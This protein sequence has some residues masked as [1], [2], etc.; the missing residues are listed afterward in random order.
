MTLSGTTLAEWD[1]LTATGHLDYHRVGIRT[2]VVGHETLSV[3]DFPVP[4][5]GNFII[6][7]SSHRSLAMPPGG[8]TIIVQSPGANR[9]FELGYDSKTGMAIR[10]EWDGISGQ[11]LFNLSQEARD[12]WSL[13]SLHVAG[14]LDTAPFVIDDRYWMFNVTVEIPFISI[15][16]VGDFHVGDLVT[17]KGETNIGTGKEM[18]VRV[19]EGPGIRE[20]P[21]DVGD[22]S[23]KGGTVRIG[24]AEGSTNPWEFSFDSEGM[25]PNWYQVTVEGITV[26]TNKRTTFNL[27]A[28]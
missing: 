13:A 26:D 22:W 5:D 18:F 10:P 8:Y 12:N 9:H 3:R 7:V 4:S 23:F 19:V 15:D 6:D 2:W 14:I 21:V 24:R 1:D 20:V 27:T 25:H 17:I 28:A 16:P 11:P